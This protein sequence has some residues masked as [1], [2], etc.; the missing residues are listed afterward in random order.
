MATN[1]PTVAWL[2]LGSN[3]GDRKAH[4]LQ[5]IARLEAVPGIAVLAASTLRESAPCGG[6][7]PQG[8][9]LNGVVR[10]ETWLAPFPLAVGVFTTALFVVLQFVVST[11]TERWLFIVGAVYVLIALYAP[12]G[13]LGYRKIRA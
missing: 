1:G 10:I 11:Y 3:L 12:K 6:G 5:A 13:V 7:P 9:F 4:L 8:A 2:G